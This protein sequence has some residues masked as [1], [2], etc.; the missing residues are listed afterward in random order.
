MLP[1][2]YVGALGTLPIIVLL[3]IVVAL[4]KV[5]IMYVLYGNDMALTSIK[6]QMSH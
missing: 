5:Q 1:F 6:I 3:L 2:L 4:G